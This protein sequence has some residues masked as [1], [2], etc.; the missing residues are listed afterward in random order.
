MPSVLEGRRCRKW[1]APSRR[2]PS[3]CGLCPLGFRLRPFRSAAQSG[4]LVHADGRV[5]EDVLLFRAR[6]PSL[7]RHP[8][9]GV[10]QGAVADGV[11]VYWEVALEH[12]AACAEAIEGVRQPRV[13]QLRQLCAAHRLRALVELEAVDAHHD[14]PHFAHNVWARRSQLRELCTPRGL[15]ALASHGGAHQAAQVVEDD[16]HARKLLRKLRQLRELPC[17]VAGRRGVPDVEH[18]AMPL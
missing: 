13:H 8:L 6:E 11:P 2:L 15:D 18:Q 16:G 9:E 12:A 7:C 3:S 10:P 1:S 5:V 14:A 4:E 17:H